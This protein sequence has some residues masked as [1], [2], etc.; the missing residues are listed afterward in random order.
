MKLVLIFNNTH[1]ILDFT[2]SN[3]T[4]IYKIESVNGNNYNS[5]TSVG[6]K[7]GNWVNGDWRFWIL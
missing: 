4:N 3:I 7:Y 6:N 2:V 1:D 5:I